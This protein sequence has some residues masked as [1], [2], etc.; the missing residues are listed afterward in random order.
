MI[1]EQYGYEYKMNLLASDLD[2]DDL[3][4][5]NN[6]VYLRWVQ[7]VAKSHWNTVA[8]EEL[9][10]ACVWVVL[11]HEIDYLKQALPGDKLVAKTWI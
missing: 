1:E 8:G 2:T 5:V 4:H 10:A 9:I 11:R 6:I 7:E 3:G